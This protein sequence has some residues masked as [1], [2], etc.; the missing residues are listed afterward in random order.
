MTW[1]TDVCEVKVGSVLMQK[2]LDEM[3]KQIGRFWRLLTVKENALDTTQG[4]C[5]ATV[6]AVLRLRPYIE[7]TRST[8]QS[9]H[10]L[11]KWMGN[12]SDAFGRLARWRTRLFKL[13]LDI[14]HRAGIK[15]EAADVLSRIRAIS[16]KATHLHD[17]FPICHV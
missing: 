4:E 10:N 6:S 13:D 7:C 8:I 16:V 1:D 2:E 3:A 15:L 5:F 14:V 12:L 17:D 9:N 11:R